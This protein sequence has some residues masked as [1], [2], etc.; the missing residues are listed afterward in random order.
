[1]QD[2]PVEQT[3]HPL[4]WHFFANAIVIVVALGDRVPID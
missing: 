2:I 1:M 4:N 3:I